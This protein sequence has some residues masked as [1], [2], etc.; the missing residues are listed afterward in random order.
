[1]ASIRKILI[2]SPI[3]LSI[4]FTTNGWTAPLS[5]TLDDFIQIALK[6]N[7]EI[8]IAAEQFLANKGVVTQARSLYYPRLTAGAGVGRRPSS[9]FR[10]RGNKTALVA[11]FSAGCARALPQGARARHPRRA[12][13]TPC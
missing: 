11:P 7:P 10:N 3:L 6:N 5:L 9:L 2:I 4:L 13:T 12:A 1:M 8:E